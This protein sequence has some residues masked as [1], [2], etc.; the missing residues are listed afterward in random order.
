MPPLLGTFRPVASAFTRYDRIAQWQT[1]KMTMIFHLSMPDQAFVLCGEQYPTRT[2]AVGDVAGIGVD[3][4]CSNC[5]QAW[6][7]FGRPVPDD[8]PVAAIS[9]DF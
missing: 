4:V 3:A 6:L 1:M 8:G 5:I 9:S 7:S 2:L